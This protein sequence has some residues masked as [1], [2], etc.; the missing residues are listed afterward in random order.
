MSARC[1]LA[2]YWWMHEILAAFTGSRFLTRCSELVSWTEMNR[3]DANERLQN[4]YYENFFFNITSHF[5]G[6]GS[7][8]LFSFVF[9]CPIY[10]HLIRS[11][12]VF[13][14]YLKSF[15]LFCLFDLVFNVVF[16]IFSI[17]NFLVL[18]FKSS[19]V[20]CRPLTFYFI[21]VVVLLFHKFC[22]ICLLLCLLIL[23]HLLL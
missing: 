17:W 16:L 23:V 13:F 7:S 14:L 20:I 8:F 19:I 22:I 9:C 6:K 3:F 21:C 10:L 4:R 2:R 18:P 12:V 11:Q 1:L 15:F 5:N